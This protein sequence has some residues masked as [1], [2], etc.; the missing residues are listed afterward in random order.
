MMTGKYGVLIFLQDRDLEGA[1]D[2]LDLQCFTM[3]SI[4]LIS[5]W[6]G[7]GVLRTGL[8]KAALFT[9]NGLVSLWIEHA[10]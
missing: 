1:F 5:H 6:L 10:S 9:E 4:Y 2:A 3:E 8:D 7:L